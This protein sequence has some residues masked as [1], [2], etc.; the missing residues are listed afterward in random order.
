MADRTSPAD[1]NKAL[2]DMG[3]LFSQDKWFPT[4]GLWKR[5]SL[6]L[7]GSTITEHWQT[8]SFLIAG[9]FVWPAYFCTVC[10]LIRGGG[11]LSLPD[12]SR[13][14]VEESIR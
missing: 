5:G 11:P 8:A 7:L 2:A 1:E 14:A 3:F 9:G 12:A 4:C 10:G 13:V 6:R